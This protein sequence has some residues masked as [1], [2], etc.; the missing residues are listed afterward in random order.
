MNLSAY[1][2]G[3][4]AGY[5]RGD[6]LPAPPSS[7]RLVLSTTD[8]KSDG[9]GLSEPSVSY[10]YSRQTISFKTPVATLGNGVSAFN[11][12]VMTFGIATSQWPTTPYAAILDQS[13]NILFYGTLNVQRAASTGDTIPFAEDSVQLHFGNYYSHYFGTLLL[14]WV[15]GTIPPAAPTSLRLALSKAD[16]TQAGLGIV[17]PVTNY[18]RLPITF[19]TPVSSPTGTSILSNGPYIFGP[20][21]AAWGFITHCAVLTST[22]SQLFQGPIT[23]PRSVNVDDSFAVP[24]GALSVLLN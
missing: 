2:Q 14:N 15:R 7:L 22:N 21:N 1:L 17:E 16:P 6:N 4:I 11:S 9:S 18:T 24:T 10:G 20:A 5:V 12:S 13:D 19:S 23:V 3:L 8:P